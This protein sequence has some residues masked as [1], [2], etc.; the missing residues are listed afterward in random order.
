MWN[1]K[2]FFHVYPL[3]KIKITWEKNPQHIVLTIVVT[4]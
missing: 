1:Y 3:K 2:N 4:E